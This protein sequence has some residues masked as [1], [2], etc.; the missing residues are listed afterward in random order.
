M[1]VKVAALVPGEQVAETEAAAG[2]SMFLGLI[3]GSFIGRTLKFTNLFNLRIYQVQTKFCCDEKVIRL[4][5]NPQ[6]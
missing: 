4:K 6:V 5:R 1:A 2:N 3:V